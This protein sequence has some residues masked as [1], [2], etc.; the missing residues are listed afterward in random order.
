MKKKELTQIEID[1]ILEN[2]LKMSMN[3]MAFNLKVSFYQVRSYMKKNNL[4]VDKAV[5]YKFKSLNKVKKEPKKDEPYKKQEWVFDI[6]NHGINPI[7]M[8]RK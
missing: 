4:M 8:F 2:R 5:I 3:Q 6:W 7:T 1:Y